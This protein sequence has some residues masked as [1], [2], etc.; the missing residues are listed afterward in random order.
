MKEG[1]LSDH[2]GFPPGN[3]TTLLYSW[4][5]LEAGLRFTFICFWSYNLYPFLLEKKEAAVAGNG[6][7]IQCTAYPQPIQKK[8]NFFIEASI[9]QQITEAVL[10]YSHVAHLTALT[11]ATKERSIARC[12]R[13]A[14][15]SSISSI[16]FNTAHVYR[17][18]LATT[19]THTQNAPSPRN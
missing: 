2:I 15:G 17:S 9:M 1:E 11:P 6:S 18:T 3:R 8:K 10:T 19:T 12:M 4:I 14:K 13:L 5:S 7:F 16:S